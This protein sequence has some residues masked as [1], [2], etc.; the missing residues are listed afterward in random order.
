MTLEHDAG[1]STYRLQIF[2]PLRDGSSSRALVYRRKGNAAEIRP[3]FGGFRVGNAELE[4]IACIG[5]TTAFGCTSVSLEHRLSSEFRFPVSYE[6]IWDVL[7]WLSE[8]ASS[9]GADLMKAFVFG[10]TSSGAHIANPLFH[11]ARDEMLHPPIQ[12]FTSIRR[13]PWHRKSIEMYD[14]DIQPDFAS[15]LWSPLLWPTGYASIPPTFFQICGANLL[16]DDALIYERELRLKYG[17]KTKAIV[18]QVL[19]H[20]FWYTHPSLT[21]SKRFAED[22]VC[23]VGWLLGLL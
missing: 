5:A 16:R 1:E 10:G 19:P 22:T 18:Y 12:A 13:R 6:D 17:V 8:H 14:Q 2:I 23:G 7:L 3:L 20:G 15:P 11:R 9:L 4:S 21:A